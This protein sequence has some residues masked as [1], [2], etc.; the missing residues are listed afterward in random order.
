M[1]EQE[2]SR[3][4]LATAYFRAAHQVLE[5][6]RVFQ[7]PL[8]VPILGVEPEAIRERH[9]DEIYHG[10][11][12]L[13]VARSTLA[14]RAL[15]EGVETRG[16]RQ[17]VVLGAGL[18]TFAYRNQFGERLRV[19]E[20]DHPATQA[21]KR[22]RLYEAGIP[23]PANVTYAPL[24]FEHED[25]SERLAAAGLDA[26]VRTFFTWLGVAPYLTGEAVGRT[27]RQIAAHPAGA[28]VAFDY[29][30]RQANIDSPQSG[31]L[32]RRVASLG[33]PFLSDFAPAEL[34]AQLRSLGFE[35]IEDLDISAMAVRLTSDRE[36]SAARSRG[37]VVLARTPVRIQPV[38]GL[39][40]VGSSPPG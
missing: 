13:V 4:A 16:V 11:R 3:T 2:P 17:L 29:G 31:E 33:E 23:V 14:E 35:H 32:A 34:E 36:S 20:V 10:I 40:A 26:G 5:H 12:F 25:L 6:G 8:A 27:L 21:W 30:E 38:A 39:R 24:D 7:D 9:F 18:D 37:R 15:K 1:F 19:F 22:R 28:E